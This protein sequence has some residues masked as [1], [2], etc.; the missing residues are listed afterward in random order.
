[1]LYSTFLKHEADIGSN[2]VTHAMSAN[3]FGWL[4]QK[5]RQMCT[6]FQGQTQ[7]AN[8]SKYVTSQ[9]VI[10]MNADPVMAP[11][12]MSQIKTDQQVGAEHTFSQKH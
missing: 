12:Y 6:W 3:H 2:L 1:M 11:D 5:L 7:K 9:Q 8:Q 10:A 4:K